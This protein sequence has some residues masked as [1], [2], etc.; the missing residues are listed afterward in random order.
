MA[1]ETSIFF[2]ATTYVNS[3]PDEMRCSIKSISTEFSPSRSHLVRFE[4]IKKDILSL[5]CVAIDI[6]T[7]LGILHLSDKYTFKKGGDFENVNELIKHLRKILRKYSFTEIAPPGNFI[8]ASLDT[9]IRLSPSYNIN[10]D[11][12]IVTA[13]QCSGNDG[14]SAMI[15]TR[16]KRAVTKINNFNLCLHIFE[17]LHLVTDNEPLNIDQNSIINSLLQNSIFPSDCKNYLLSCLSTTLD[18]VPL[19]TDLNESSAYLKPIT[20][21]ELKATFLRTLAKIAAYSHNPLTFKNVSY[22]EELAALYKIERQQIQVQTFNFL[23]EDNVT[24]TEENA[25]T[26]RSLIY[27]E[28]LKK[29]KNLYKAADSEK[30]KFKTTLLDLLR[31]H[32]FINN[33][34]LIFIGNNQHLY[35]EDIPTENPNLYVCNNH[36]S[37]ED[38]NWTFAICPNFN[39][40]LVKKE[41]I[42]TFNEIG[43][44]EKRNFAKSLNISNN[45]MIP[46]NVLITIGA[47]L[48]YRLLVEGVLNNIDDKDKI[49]A[50][51][52]LSHWYKKAFYANDS[53]MN[54]LRNSLYYL[55]E[56]LSI[57][58]F[59]DKDKANNNHINQSFKSPYL[60]IFWNLLLAEVILKNEN[61]L[62]NTNIN[63][64]DL[65]YKINDLYLP[66][67]DII[68][69]ALI[70][71]H[72]NLYPNVRTVGQNSSLLYSY[73]YDT[74]KQLIKENP[75]YIV[76][77]LKSVSDSTEKDV[78]DDYFSAL[79]C[80]KNFALCKLLPNKLNINE[81]GLAIISSI[82]DKIKKHQKSIYTYLNNN[83]T[84]SANEIVYRIFEYKLQQNLK[85][86]VSNDSK[87]IN[88]ENKTLPLP[89]EA[90]KQDLLSK[91]VIAYDNAKSLFN[92]KINSR[93]ECLDIMSECA[94]VLG[95]TMYPNP[96]VEK[97]NTVISAYEYVTFSEDNTNI[98]YKNVNQ[99]ITPFRL[100]IN[101]A[102]T[103]STH[104]YI[105][106]QFSKF[107]KQEYNDIDEKN[108]QSIFN[109]CEFITQIKLKKGNSCRC[110]NGLT[111]F[112][113]TDLA[114]KELLILFNIVAS[115]GDLNTNIRNITA[116]NKKLADNP[117][118]IFTQKN[119]IKTNS[120]FKTFTNNR[121]NSIASTP[122]ELNLELIAQKNIETQQVQKILAP[123]FAD[124][125]VIETDNSTYESTNI[126]EQTTISNIVEEST[127]SNSDK[128]NNTISDTQSQNTN[129]TFAQLPQSC[130]KLLIRLLQLP[131]FTLSDFKKICSEV[132]LMHNAALE[133]INT[134]SLDNFDCTLIEEDTPMFFDKELLSECFN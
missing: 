117:L 11:E 27:L 2:N 75:S 4:K 7:L 78:Y 81:R 14:L 134:W 18:R 107:V 42:R 133:I 10:N 66:I 94:S 37:L 125:K 40:Q 31:E 64:K 105:F 112:K 101:A 80:Y 44:H 113:F 70:L 3:L 106:E 57:N 47:N 73:S 67:E 5:P 115:N 118:D 25:S 63:T 53:T 85:T 20:D 68:F 72:Q 71:C 38:N 86:N 123:I 56:I 39:R 15:A 82:A 99:I 65:D 74:Y 30:N 93:A 110:S 79:K 121:V 97:Y 29:Y 108:L 52:M 102:T 59:L 48:E 69:Y 130:Q 41:K 34:E 16:I 19:K 50:Q 54:D 103:F 89:L 62:N 129:E 43:K 17:A 28:K 49:K 131:N 126:Q 33:N 9:I 104:Q 132:G 51:I 88:E 92:I 109:Y 127:S 13:K 122:T 116:I 124:E 32:N 76:D 119:Y 100:A 111:E 77:I 21:L 90:F 120:V 58:T 55:G 96:N 45:S 98:D 1:K 35:I 91:G 26:L 24:K 23:K 12:D 95:I 128:L 83:S 22:A 46:Q 8:D 61:K 87:P 84:N 6:K 114:K 36:R 60:K